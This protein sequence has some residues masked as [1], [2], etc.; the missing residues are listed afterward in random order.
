[1]STEPFHVTDSNFEQTTQNQQSRI[2][3]FLG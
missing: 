3:G 2:G 1:M